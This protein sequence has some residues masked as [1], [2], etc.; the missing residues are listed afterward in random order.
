LEPFA[1]PSRSPDS[2]EHL[3][4]EAA[5]DAFS[6][7]VPTLRLPT[8][9]VPPEQE[10][11]PRSVRRFA[12]RLMSVSAVACAVLLALA[13]HAHGAP[14]QRHGLHVARTGLEA[15]PLR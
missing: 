11:R 13:W 7:Q 4:Q 15:T 12:I 14:R 6:F 5:F 8:G 1:S 3:E 9:L 10:E 2:F